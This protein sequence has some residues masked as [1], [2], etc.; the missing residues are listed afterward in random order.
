MSVDSHGAKTTRSPWF[1]PW[2]YDELLH[3]A[4]RRY[5][6]THR[7]TISLA[8]CLPRNNADRILAHLL[9]RPKR[10]GTVCSTTVTP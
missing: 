5:Q 1:W 10:G 7:T 8:K 4:K 2:D 3:A 9:T 6:R